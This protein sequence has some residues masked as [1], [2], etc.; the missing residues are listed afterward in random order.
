[1]VKSSNPIKAIGG[2]FELADLDCE[3]GRMPVEGIALNTC[4]NALE[5]IIL[6]LADVKRIFIPYFTC[7]AV[8]EPLKRLSIEYVFYHINEHPLHQCRLAHTSSISNQQS[9][10]IFLEHL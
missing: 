9:A 10:T 4:R 2:Y 1:M 6:Q 7:E 5:Y 8:V 3:N